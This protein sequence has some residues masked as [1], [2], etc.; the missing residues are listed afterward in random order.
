MRPD[1]DSHSTTRSFTRFSLLPHDLRV[2][3]WKIVTVQPRNLDIWPLRVGTF[4]YDR[5]IEG[6]ARYATWRY[7]T[8]QP[9][10]A[11]LHTTRESREIGLKHYSLNF[12]SSSLQ[13]E[14]YGLKVTIPPSIY[15]NVRYDRVFLMG[16]VNSDDGGGVGWSSTVAETLKR[17]DRE[18][19][20]Q[21]FNIPGIT[22]ATDVSTFYLGA[23]RGISSELI[24]QKL[25][26][27]KEVLFFS[28]VRDVIDEVHASSHPAV[29]DC[30]ELEDS[31]IG[32]DLTLLSVLKERLP[33]FLD[34]ERQRCSTIAGIGDG[35]TDSQP[36]V[37]PS[38]KWVTLMV[39]GAKVGL[40]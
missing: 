28:C 14:R 15:F 16:G 36:W 2:D 23:L 13:D 21:V 31:A 32:G 37:G 20:Q 35:Q 19:A 9:I 40:Q 26:K 11:V 30:V 3:I 29:L 18:F 39:N 27:Q 25:D 4:N 5:E 38:V 33:E 1:P 17:R 10:P 34:E 6:Q 8:T 22:V 12:R 24:L 7:F